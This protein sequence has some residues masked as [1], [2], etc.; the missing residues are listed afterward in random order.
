MR[1]KGLMRLACVWLADFAVSGR[2]RWWHR[3]WPKRYKLGVLADGREVWLLEIPWEAGDKAAAG[4]LKR[5]LGRLQ[6]QNGEA[7]KLGMPIEMAALVA[8]KYPAVLRDGRR[9]CCCEL[10]R[11]LIK[12]RGS[13][14]GCEVGLLGL[15]EEWQA[16]MVAELLAAGVRVAVN[17]AYAD[18]LAAAYWRQGV[19]L[20]V[21]SGRKLLKSCDIVYLLQGGADVV[22]PGLRGRV[23]PFAEPKVYVAGHFGGQY[24]Y[25]MFA[26]GLAAA[27]TEPAERAN[28][29]NLLD[30]GSLLT[31]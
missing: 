21:V 16:D 3:L 1:K 26:A 19:A 2:Q 6:K 27:L 28:Y 30:K 24:R 15:N 31:L 12:Q 25:G 20:P 8:D 10:V 17:G 18:R 11:R 13:V 29:A 9:L 14:Q 5:R 23:V 22:P 7:F 4:W